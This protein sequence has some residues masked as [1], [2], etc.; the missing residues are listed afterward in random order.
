MFDIVVGSNPLTITSFDL[1]LDRSGRIANL[2]LYTRP[3][4]HVGFQQTSAGWTLFD[5][6]N[7]V[8]NG[9][10]NAT[11]ADFADFVAPANATT[12][13]YLTALR[14]STSDFNYIDGT[15][16]GNVA[17]S[18]ADL[19]ILEGTGKAYAFSSNF[20]PRVFSG[21]VNYTVGQVGPD[22]QAIPE[23]V[24]ATLSVLAMASLGLVSTRRPGRTE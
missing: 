19:S 16:V 20:T 13:I 12:A 1:N 15:A 2:E 23:P 18:N 8:S 4:T 22:P 6:I 14:S 9:D 3:G 7:V 11:P 10:G 24:T 21:T 5:S 17:A